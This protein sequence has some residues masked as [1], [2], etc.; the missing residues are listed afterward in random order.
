MSKRKPIYVLG[1]ALS[2]DGS[3]CLLK[4]GRIAFAIEKERITRKKHDGH[5]DTEAINY[6]LEAEGIKFTDLD[7]VVQSGQF[8]LE[9][10]GQFDYGRYGKRLTNVYPEVPVAFVSHH[11]AHAYNAIGLAPMDQ[12]AIMIIDGV[13]DTIS[14]CIDLED[15]RFIKEIQSEVHHLYYETVSF[16][17]YEN[18]KIKTI[19]KDFSH[20]VNGFHIPMFPNTLQHSI[21]NMYEAGGRYCIGEW[22]VAGKLMGLAPYGRPGIYNDN[23]FEFKDGKV[24]INYNCLKQFKRPVRG[25][26]DLKADFQHYADIAYWVQKETEKTILYLSNSLYNLT[27]SENLCYSGGVALNAVANA[28][29][30]NNTE[31]KNLYLTPAAGDN[32]LAIGCAYYGWLEVLKQ[33]RVPHDGSSA[34]SKIYTHEEIESAFKKFTKVNPDTKSLITTVLED[35]L[36]N[37]YLEKSSESSFK[38]QLVIKD[39][40]IY[41]LI[42]DTDTC[43]CLPKAATN[44]DAI[45]Y[46]DSKTLLSFLMGTSSLDSAVNSGKLIVTDAKV[47]FQHNPEIANQVYLKLTRYFDLYRVGGFLFSTLHQPLQ[48]QCHHEDKLISEVADILAQ[49]K[50]V[51][52]FQGK[53][54]FGP[55]ALGNRSILADPRRPDVQNFINSRVKFREDF[56]PFAPA[57]VLEEVSEYFEYEGE[58]PYMIMVAQVKEKWL[59]KLPGVTHKD[60]SARIQTVTSESNLKFYSLLKKFKSLTG[61]PMLLNTSFNRKGMPIIESPAQALQF[62]FECDLDALVV[63]NYILYKDQ[64]LEVLKIDTKQVEAL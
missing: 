18:N 46:S 3:A 53:S 35:A 49:G 60:N 30:L 27:K 14:R 20:I 39:L 7:L 55:R 28:K 15:N 22:N 32:G 9:E 37:S 34:F 48:I 13:G 62:F 31:F 51:G 56:R 5:N 38:C 47:G 29:I 24:R 10:Y 45:I 2:H 59:G 40:T 12:M 50:V 19:F 21:G 8:G 25:Y 61:I 36:P 52:W 11:L 42:V 64:N 57:V 4:D 41:T 44:P 26:G 6:C 54:E 23:L 1:T 58:S 43:V 63:E 33:Q 16:Y 17:L